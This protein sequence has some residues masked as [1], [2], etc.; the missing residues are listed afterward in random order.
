MLASACTRTLLPSTA[1]SPIWQ[2]ASTLQPGPMTDGAM[3]CAAGE[4][5]APSPMHTPSLIR[6][7]GIDTS[8]FWSS[9]SKWA[10]R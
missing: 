8:T 3:T 9:T 6:K 4:T 5:S 7:P 1:Y 10:L 2:P